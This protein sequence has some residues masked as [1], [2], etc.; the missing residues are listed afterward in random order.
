MTNG[1]FSKP[2][3]EHK[4]YPA[5]FGFS[6][7]VLSIVRKVLPKFFISE[8]VIGFGKSFKEAPQ[9]SPKSEFV[10]EVLGITDAEGAYHFEHCMAI[11]S[12]SK[13]FV[14]GSRPR[15]FGFVGWC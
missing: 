2:P 4:E 12:D 3:Q 7:S 15:F 14:D 10:Q 8:Q 1:G 6:G 11:E 13:D 5:L 9:S